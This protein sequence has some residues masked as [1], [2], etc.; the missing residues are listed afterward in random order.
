MSARGLVPVLRVQHGFDRRHQH[1]QTR[2]RSWL[3]EGST[4][5]IERE[6]LGGR[7]MRTRRERKR[8]GRFGLGLIR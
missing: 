5:E 2:I 7:V 4:V 8:D 1:E 3:E 6:S